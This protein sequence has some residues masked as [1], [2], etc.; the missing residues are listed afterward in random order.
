MYIYI[1][2]GLTGRKL[3]YSIL[4]FDLCIYFRK[5]NPIYSKNILKK[6]RKFYWSLKLYNYEK[7]DGFDGYVNGNGYE[8]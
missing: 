2:L 7:V 5:R 8:R 4:V 3:K 1:D 6:R